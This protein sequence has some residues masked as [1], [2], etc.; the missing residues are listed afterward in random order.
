M[1]SSRCASPPLRD[2]AP[3]AHPRAQ[4]TAS[5]SALVAIVAARARYTAAHPAVRLEDLVLYTTTQTH[6]LGVKAG[7]VL[8][9]A[10]RALPVEKADDFALRGET[11]RNA[12]EED[13]AKGKEPFLIGGYTWLLSR[14]RYLKLKLCS[15]SRRWGRRA[16]AR[17]TASTRSWNDPRCGRN[18]PA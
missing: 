12:I 18:R 1:A 14:E 2:G 8:G 7:L 11:V 5:D 4:T 13:E 3:H 6:S 9:L 17:S 10:V 15:Q 16:R